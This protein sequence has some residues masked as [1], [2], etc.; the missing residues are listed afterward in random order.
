M[1]KVFPINGKWL[2]KVK[3]KP[4]LWNLLLIRLG[5][6]KVKLPRS[7]LPDMTHDQVARVGLWTREQRLEGKTTIILC[8]ARE[9]KYGGAWGVAAY[10]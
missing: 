3:T 9:T 6:W 8:R 5:A 2:V 7:S 4:S 10:P 1:G